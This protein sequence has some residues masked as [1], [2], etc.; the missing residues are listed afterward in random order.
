[1]AREIIM[2]PP[3]MFANLVV[4]DQDENADNAAAKPRD[5]VVVDIE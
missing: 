5:S 1:M 2:P 4:L 3:K